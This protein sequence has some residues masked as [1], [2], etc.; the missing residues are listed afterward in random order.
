MRR[1]SHSV[2]G[3]VVA[4][5]ILA[6][7]FDRDLV[8]FA[9]PSSWAVV[10]GFAWLWWCGLGWPA[11]KVSRP[12]WIALGVGVGFATALYVGHQRVEFATAVRA[13]VLGVAAGGLASSLAR[14]GSHPRLRGGAWAVVAAALVVGSVDKP[15]GRDFLASFSRALGAHHSVSFASWFV[16]M[17]VIAVVIAFVPLGARSTTRPRRALVGGERDVG[18][19][20]IIK[21]PAVGTGLVG[22]L[23]APWEWYLE[24]LV[25]ALLLARTAPL[26]L[27]GS[28]SGSY[29]VLSGVL[30]L[31]WAITKDASTVISDYSLAALLPGA[32]SS[33]RR[34]YV[35]PFLV[36]AVL[37]LGI[38]LLVVGSPSTH[39]L[40][41]GAL[42]LLGVAFGV[43]GVGVAMRAIAN[44]TPS[45]GRSL[46]FGTPILLAACALAP[47]IQWNTARTPHSLEAE[48]ILTG[49]LFAVVVGIIGTS[50]VSWWRVRV[51]E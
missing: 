32:L 36:V 48:A 35:A 42:S 19:R 31:G 43:A 13:G 30:L 50:F 40:A 46:R 38:G 2:A 7:V 28:I 3:A 15:L 10:A 37:A 16:A 51:L 29:V 44:E 5:A 49:T 6:A 25:G 17:G 34:R 27:V 39:V 8:N 12:V 41:L 14:F 26:V 20:M 4:L 24:V 45:R 47:M 23:R 11:M 9:A 22:I 33:Y 18:A 21:F 1:S